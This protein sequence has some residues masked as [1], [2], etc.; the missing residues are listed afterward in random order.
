M[1]A[2]SVVINDSGEFA[3]PI[4]SKGKTEE[5]G[6]FKTEQ[7]ANEWRATKQRSDDPPSDVA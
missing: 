6:G 3:V 5:V 1:A 7:K 2:Y 4:Q